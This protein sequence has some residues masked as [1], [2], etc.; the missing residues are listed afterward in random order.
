M[1]RNGDWWNVSVN[2]RPSYEYPPLFIWLEAL[3]M[4]VLGVSDFAAKFPSA[5]LGFGVIVLIFLI[6]GELSDQFWLP[7]IGMW[8]MLFSQYFIKYAMHA[9]TDVPFTFFFLLALF[10]YV[11]GLRQPRYLVLC[12]LAIGLGILTRSVIGLIPL[13]IIVF[14]SI[15]IGRAN[16]LRSWHFVLLLLFAISLPLIWYVSQY[17]IHGNQFLLS[18]FGFVQSKIAEKGITLSRRLLGCFGYVWLFLLN[19]HPWLPLVA[20]G[21]VMQI[22]AVIRKR[23]TLATLLVVWTMCVLV[24]FSLAEAKVLRYVMPVL[25]AFSILAAIPLNKWIPAARKPRLLKMIYPLLIAAAIAM[26]VF[27]RP[28]LRGDDMRALAPIAEAHSVPE[29]HVVLYTYGERRFDI[30]HQLL[31]YGNRY[32]DHVFDQGAVKAGLQSGQVAIMNK[33]GYEQLR[34][35]FDLPTE[36]LGESEDYVCI[37]LAHRDNVVSALPE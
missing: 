35:S 27:A 31:W 28:M 10:F 18:H 16:L 1:L 7:I 32:C 24:P 17:Q 9:M 11:K 12:G 20:I 30:Q 25:P 29:R 26:T 22:K 21:F 19:Y 5:I 15:L 37:R 4:K 34:R 6:T 33:G 3:S 2:G 36:V 13:G 14:H 23:E 8:I